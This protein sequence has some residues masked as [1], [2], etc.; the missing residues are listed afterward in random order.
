MREI[1][2]CLSCKKDMENIDPR[3]VKTKN[4]KQVMPSKCSICNN[5]KSKFISQ[6]SDLFDSLGLNT[7]QNR[8]KALVPSALINLN[9][10]INKFLLAGDRFMPEM[11]LRQSQFVYSACG[12]FTRHKERINKFKQTGDTRYIY[13]NDLDKTCF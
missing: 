9:N 7:P 11:H 13:R 2:Y 1:T 5:K 8:M 6:G 10:I 3:I 12:P 4:N